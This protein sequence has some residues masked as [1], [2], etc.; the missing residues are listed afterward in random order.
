MDIAPSR[1]IDLVKIATLRA[2][3]P[4][5]TSTLINR[6]LKTLLDEGIAKQEGSQRPAVYVRRGPSA[7]GERSRH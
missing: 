1:I 3:Y 6:E 2:G 4:E 7:V 5:G